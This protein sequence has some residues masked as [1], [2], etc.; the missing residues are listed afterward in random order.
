MKVRMQ[1][2]VRGF[3]ILKYQ[4]KEKIN[5][6]H[7]GNV[8]NQEG[9]AVQHHFINMH[10]LRYSTTSGNPNLSYCFYWNASCKFQVS[11]LK[12]ILQPSFPGNEA[13]SLE[14]AFINTANMSN[15]IFKSLPP[16]SCITTSS[17][18]SWQSFWSL[19]RSSL[20]DSRPWASAHQPPRNPA[21][22]KF[23]PPWLFIALH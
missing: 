16:R 19:R 2:F 18:R 3:H 5:S 7:M 23:R 15:L 8:L 22:R 10:T 17:Q 12:A 6:C 1:R 20:P 21:N 11:N 4:T 9:H 14:C 13:S